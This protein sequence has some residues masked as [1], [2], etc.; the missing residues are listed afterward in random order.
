MS[1]EFFELKESTV[2]NSVTLLDFASRASP[3]QI[4]PRQ[5]G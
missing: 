5:D 1:S 2:L 4:Q 3:F